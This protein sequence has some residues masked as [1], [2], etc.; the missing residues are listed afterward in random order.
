MDVVL[1][2]PEFNSEVSKL[3]L[4][5][6]RIDKVVFTVGSVLR[7][8]DA[9]GPALGKMIGE[10]GLDGWMLIEGDQTPEDELGYIKRLAPKFLLLVDAAEMGLEPGEVRALC[11]DDV[12]R[13]YLFTTHSMPITYLLGQLK[14]ACEEV[15]FL[16]VQPQQTDFFAP[17]TQ[18]VKAA[19]ENI[20][21]ALSSENDLDELRAFRSL[22]E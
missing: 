7:G 14:G 12:E 16:G 3:I 6:E 21:Y 22:A 1:K 5:E 15:V 4:P 18:N 17:L 11:G 10:R 8:D 19:I 9:A 20:Y 13:K 2:E